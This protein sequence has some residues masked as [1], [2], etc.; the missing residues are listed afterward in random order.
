MVRWYLLAW[1]GTT[2]R[3]FLTKI[4]VSRTVLDSLARGAP[5]AVLEED[6]SVIYDPARYGSEMI[7]DVV[8]RMGSTGTVNVTWAI[9][10]QSNIKFPFNVYPMTDELM[11][12]EGQWNSSIRLNF[13]GMPSNMSEAVLNVQFLNASGGAMLG[14]ITSLKIVFPA[15]PG[16]AET[17][18]MTTLIVVLCTVVG[19]VL[20]ILVIIVA[21]KIVRSRRR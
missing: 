21:R 1:I 16:E 20:I 11:F 15:K 9:T 6:N 12:I 4:N 18:G 8:R 13:G 2:I 5:H 3:D 17:S 19:V 14:N 10:S 7:L